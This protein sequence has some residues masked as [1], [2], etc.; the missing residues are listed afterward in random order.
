MMMV[1][2]DRQGECNHLISHSR[3]KATGGD[4]DWIS[5]K[6]TSRS[7]EPAVLISKER[8]RRESSHQYGEHHSSV[9]LVEQAEEA[10]GRNLSF[11]LTLGKS[12]SSILADDAQNVMIKKDTFT[13]IIFTGAVI[14]VI[15]AKHAAFIAT[16]SV[17]LFVTQQER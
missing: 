15:L 4:C 6:S 9:L 7:I 1:S 13:W 2:V 17:C 16:V 12:E 11:L 10:P 14:M 8:G 3:K 5:F